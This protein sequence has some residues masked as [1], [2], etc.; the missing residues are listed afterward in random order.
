MSECEYPSKPDQT[1]FISNR[2]LEKMKT[3]YDTR[4]TIDERKNARQKVEEYLVSSGSCDKINKKLSEKIK[5]QF[6]KFDGSKINEKDKLNE[7]FH[8]NMSC[9]LNSIKKGSALEKYWYDNPVI[10]GKTSVEGIAAVLSLNG[11]KNQSFVI[12]TPRDKNNDELA[13]ECLVGMFALN[14]LRKYVPNFMYVYSYSKCSH[15]VIDDKKVINWCNNGSTEN[16][17]YLVS[18]L[19]S[20]SMPLSE[21]IT[22]DTF[23]PRGMIKTFV[24]LIN[25]LSVAEITFGYTHY[26]LHSDNVLVSTFKSKVDVPIYIDKDPD[27]AKYIDSKHIPFIIDYGCS[28]VYLEGYGS[29]GKLGL[30][31][32]GVNAYDNYPMYD[33]YKLLCFCAENLV[34]KTNSNKGPYANILN[35]QKLVVIQNMFDFFNQGSIYDRVSKRLKNK[36]DFYQIKGNYKSISYLKFLEHLLTILQYDSIKDRNMS[37]ITV[38][39][40]SI[41]VCDFINM[42]TGDKLPSSSFELCQLIDSKYVDEEKLKEIIENFDM[43]SEIN[44]YEK[45]IKETNDMAMQSDYVIMLEDDIV[46]EG[47]DEKEFIEPIK[48]LV[49]I[50]DRYIHYTNWKKSLLCINNDENYTALLNDASNLARNISGYLEDNIEIIK[51]NREYIKNNPY[52]FKSSFWRSDD[53]ES[54]NYYVSALPIDDCA[55]L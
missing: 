17:S 10:M 28:R 24:Q 19:I 4:Y 55:S 45:Y 49:K 12:K 46:Y 26:D 39:K 51:N 43:N 11:D 7:S 42:V 15:M 35:N 27:N 38:S 54:L 16:T 25:A 23:S 31:N 2:I 1:A 8:A 9:A 20:N 22:T 36:D 21:I 33:V 3:Y 18:E 29:F 6:Y 37:N 44:K 48:K 41:N 14:K 5:S 50:Y 40:D 47:I 13:H 53:D 34:R 52:D 32:Y 30:E